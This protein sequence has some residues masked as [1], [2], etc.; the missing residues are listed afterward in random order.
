MDEDLK[1]AHDAARQWRPNADADTGVSQ[2]RAGP[3]V[4]RVDRRIMADA[5]VK[6]IVCGVG[7]VRDTVAVV[8]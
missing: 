1:P 3:A 4:A 7:G 5:I 2:D 8:V 6:Q